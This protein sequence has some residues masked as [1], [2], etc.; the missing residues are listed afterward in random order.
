MDTSLL[1]MLF[2]PLILRDPNPD[3]PDDR[4]LHAVQIL[5]S[6]FDYYEEIFEVYSEILPIFFPLSLGSR[7]QA[8]RYLLRLRRTRSTASTASCGR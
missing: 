4:L 7:I 6:F 5:R 3:A 1:A 8:R 2:A